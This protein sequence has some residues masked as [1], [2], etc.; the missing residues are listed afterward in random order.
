MPNK[1]QEKGE[2]MNIDIL[3]FLMENGIILKSLDTKLLMT[4]DGMYE[5]GGEFVVYSND[6]GLDIYRGTNFEIA[7]QYLKGELK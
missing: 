1:R 2:K 5:L 3:N 4:A 7:L 6:S